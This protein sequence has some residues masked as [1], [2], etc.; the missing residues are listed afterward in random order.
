MSVC[1][2]IFNWK[3]KSL[4][5]P[6]Q[7]KTSPWAIMKVA[8]NI[9]QLLPLPLLLNK[10]KSGVTSRDPLGQRYYKTTLRYIH[11][12]KPVVGNNEKR[13]LITD[14]RILIYECGSL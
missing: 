4:T 12:N 6:G 13:W 8:N 10:S 2:H 7:S 5:G 9:L 1:K 14:L 3:E 11:I